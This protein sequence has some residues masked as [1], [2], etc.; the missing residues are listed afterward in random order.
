MFGPLTLTLQ[1]ALD[2]SAARSAADTVATVRSHF[3]SQINFDVPLPRIEPGT[4]H[5][6]YAV[7][8]AAGVPN[9]EA[10]RIAEITTK[11][12]E[13]YRT[14]IR[15]EAHARYGFRIEYHKV[16]QDIIDYELAVLAG[17]AIPKRLTG[18]K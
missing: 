5:F 15:N 11:A 18:K 6:R 16:V 9:K 7:L 10:C 12:A 1:N 4:P 8:I 3:A 13:H 2:I 17:V 14:D